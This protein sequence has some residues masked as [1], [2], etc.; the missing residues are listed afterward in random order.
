MRRSF[1][2]TLQIGALAAALVAATSAASSA[3]SFPD[4][5]DEAALY[6]AAKKEG[7]LT[8]YQ[9]GPLEPFRLIADAFEAKYP[10]IKVQILKLSGVA[11]Y[12][13]FA[14][15]AAA[16]QH[17][18]DH[19]LMSDR[20]SM[21]KLIEEGLIA[22]WRVPTIDRIPEHARHGE[23]AYAPAT[24]VINIAYNTELV[25]P[26]EAEILGK[27]WK[28]VLDPRFKGRFAISNSKTGV[29]YG[30]VALFM[31]PKYADEFGPE[32]LKQVVAQKPAM[33]TDNTVLL[34]RVAAGEHDFAFWSWD[35]QSIFKWK[36]GAPIR[37]VHP[38]P[39]PMYSNFVLAVPKNAPHP[40]AGRLF[41]NW[42]FSEDGARALE[43]EFGSRSAMIG[44]PDTS[45]VVKE[46]WYDPV[47]EPYEIDMKRWEAN[48]ENDMKVW[49]S[50]QN[51][52]R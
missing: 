49:H 47:T 8:W 36:Q 34:E 23:F 48:Y 2:R 43:Q 18:A 4:P 29:S 41:Q 7:T 51:A 27:T 30:A 11:Q 26:E 20:P 5:S 45:P 33:Y 24:T 35:A 13:R 31:D 46:A 39:T 21:D 19:L 50:I 10:G 44:M 1:F 6:A 25:T 17:I 3:Q 14:Q 52:A 40:N 28:G 16:G 15:E 32:F 38:S 37:F 12:Q 42:W 9:A 22:E